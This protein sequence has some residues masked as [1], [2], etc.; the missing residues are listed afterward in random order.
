MGLD[1]AVDTTQSSLLTT[2]TGHLIVY[3]NIFEGLIFFFYLILLSFNIQI[4]GSLL[5]SWSKK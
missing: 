4:Y 3:N 2:D 5:P 1:T